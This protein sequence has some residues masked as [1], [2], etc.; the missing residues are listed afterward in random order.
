MSGQSKGRCGRPARA[1]AGRRLWRTA[2][3][4][5]D[6]GNGANLWIVGEGLDKFDTKLVVDGGRG[7]ANLE[8][9]A[10]R[11]ERRR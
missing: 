8:L 2:G 1:D 7:A 11:V 5:L 9:V 4:A 3:R 10:W 6:H